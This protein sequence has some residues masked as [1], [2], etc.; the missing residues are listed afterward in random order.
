MSDETI[1]WEKDKVQVI[2]GGRNAPIKISVNAE[3]MYPED[4]WELIGT[5]E[6][7]IA[8]YMRELED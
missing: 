5:I 6:E 8:A 7:A 1:V 3:R 2:L 4:A